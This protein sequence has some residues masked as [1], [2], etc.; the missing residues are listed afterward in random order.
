VSDYKHEIVLALVESGLSGS[1]GDMT[2]CQAHEVAEVALRVL[3]P[4][5]ERHEQRLAEQSELFDGWVAY[6]ERVKEERRADGE[7]LADA[8][9]ERYASRRVLLPKLIEEFKRLRSSRQAWAEEALKMETIADRALTF[10]SQHDDRLAFVSRRYQQDGSGANA[11][12]NRCTGISADALAWFAVGRR[13]EPK[14][15]EYPA[16]PSDLAACQRTYDMAPA[17]LQERM[18]PVLAKYRAAVAER[19]PEV[20]AGFT[21]PQCTVHSEQTGCA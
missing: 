8:L 17:F 16:D 7:A 3:L 4:T 18:A 9:G 5:I 1:A 15:S 11:R 14:R 10:Y 6:R 12:R 19:Y 2:E 13:D 21:R 20:E